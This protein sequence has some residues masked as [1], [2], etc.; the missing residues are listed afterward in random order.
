MFFPSKFREDTSHMRGLWSA[1]EEG[2]KVLPAQIISQIPSAYNIQN[3]KMPYFMLGCTQP[4]HGCF[5]E[6]IPLHWLK[7]ACKVQPVPRERNRK[8]HARMF[9]HTE[10][11][12]NLYKFPK[13]L[14]LKYFILLLASKRSMPRPERNKLL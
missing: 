2:R 13:N 4:C 11:H 10:Y 9:F 6:L 3:A 12:S 1:S 7:I 8:N 5:S 14:N